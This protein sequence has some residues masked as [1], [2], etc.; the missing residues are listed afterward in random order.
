MSHSYIA[1][2]V[3]AGALV[4]SV[5]GAVA[6]HAASAA[7]L[8]SPAYQGQQVEMEMPPDPPEAEGMTASPQ[9][10]AAMISDEP[11]EGGPGMTGTLGE[12]QT[13]GQ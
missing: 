13:Q 9:S 4:L 1:R 11:V 6:P 8:P 5:G 12:D 3:A 7:A 2:L 10:E